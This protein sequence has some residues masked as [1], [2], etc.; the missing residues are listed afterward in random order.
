[1]SYNFS[2]KIVT[3]NL[4][5]YLDAAN[6]KSIVSGSTTW[7]DLSRNNNNGTLVNTVTFNGSNGGNVVFNG[8]TTNYI[9]TNYIFA[10]SSSYSI[11]VWA[12]STSSGVTN[13]LLGNADSTSGLNGTD[14]IWGYPSS[15]QLYIARRAGSNDAIRDTSTSAISNLLTTIHHVFVT[16]DHTGVG[17]KIFVDGV[18]VGQ[19][20][21]L[22]FLST[23]SLK[24]G[25]DA[26]GSDA[27]NGSVYSV[28]I[29]NRALSPSEAL[30]NYNA[31]KSRFGLI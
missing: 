22:G 2:P 29:Y 21:T 7:T 3:E 16:Y 27:F 17:T 11:G 31:T 4:V 15:T 6:S 10:G 18:Q 28:Q 19:N 25:K 12:K 1:M 23:L 20:T 30:Q 14:I 13:R 5:L 26:G 9:Q 24:I 8:V